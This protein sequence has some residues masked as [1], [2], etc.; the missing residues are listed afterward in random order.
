MKQQKMVLFQSATKGLFSG[1]RIDNLGEI[2]ARA[3]RRL[4]R[5]LHVA[6][7]Q[8]DGK[9]RGDAAVRARGA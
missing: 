6:D 2:N 3:R 1:E 9:R 7:E 8:P 5:R 4:A